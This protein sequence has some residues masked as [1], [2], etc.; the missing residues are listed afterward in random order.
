MPPSAAICPHCGRPGLYPNVRAA[1][2]PDEVTALERRYKAAAKDAGSRNAGHILQDFECEI[3]TSQAVIARSASELQRLAK[4]DKEIYATYYALLGAGVI[5]HTGDKWALLRAL[6]DEA[7]FPGYK[8]DI[9][10]A[11]LTL[12]THGLS[13]YGDCHIVLR[14][15]M[16]AH[17]ASVFEENS[18]MFMRN[19]GVRISE[20]NNLPR[21]FRSTWADRGKLCVAKL[22]G[23]IEGNTTRGEYSKLLLSQGATTADDNFVEV[24]VWGPMTI[25]TFEQ[26]TIKA[27]TRR[28][29]HRV[30]IDALNE[31]LSKLSVRLR[32]I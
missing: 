17:R 14:T 11:A 23:K 24:H 10:F 18:T 26:I 28:R 19:H 12:D 32:V 30:I 7:L 22:F 6:A 20:A 8:E 16:I 25:R 1:E 9:R 21:G 4:S 5:S 27:R 3:G 13:N 2:D 29:A 31:S 15:E